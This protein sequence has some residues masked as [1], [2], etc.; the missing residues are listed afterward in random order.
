MIKKIILIC[1]FL[2]ALSFM[3]FPVKAQ[4]EDPLPELPNA[5]LTPKNPFYFFDKAA[6]A[7]SEFFTFGAEAKAKLQAEHALERIAEVKAML[8]KKEVNPQGLNVAL[9]R[10]RDN[11]AKAAKI[12]QKEQQKGKDVSKLAKDLDTDFELTERLLKRILEKRQ[13]N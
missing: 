1:L 7:I 9:D 3:H 10:L 11:V 6:E 12:I 13:I 4:T 2:G 8:A 5:G